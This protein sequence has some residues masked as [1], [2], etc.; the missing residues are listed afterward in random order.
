[1]SPGL[2][3]QG[4]QRAAFL[5][6][7][8][9]QAEQNLRSGKLDQAEN[10]CRA[11]L[12]EDS[13][14]LPALQMLGLALAQKKQFDAAEEIFQRFLAINPNSASVLSNLGN[15]RHLKGDETG[16]E[17]YYRKSIALQGANP[18]THF[19]L[20]LALKAQ[21]KLEDSLAAL[22]EA[23]KRKPDYVD[24]MVQSGVVLLAMKRPA[25]AIESLDR[26]LSLRADHFEAL[27]NKGLALVSLESY[28]EAK[29]CLARAAALNQN[30]H[31][32]FLALGKT[33]KLLQENELATSSLARAAALKPDD[34][35]T[36]VALAGV[37]LA[38]GW[39]MAA[40]DEA[41]KALALA[42]DSEEAL[43]M[44]GRV[45]AELNR[46]DES[47]ALQ[48]R[49]TEVAPESIRAQLVLGTAYLARGLTDEA[50]TVFE[51]ARQMEPSNARAFLNILRTDRIK[52]GDPRLAEM[53]AFLADEEKLAVGD[54][55]E[56][57]FAAGRIYDDLK[58]YDHAFSHFEK[59]NALQMRANPTQEKT[60]VAA[61]ERTIQTFTK[62]FIEKR[63][64]QG[65]SSR[66]PIFVL[67]M[68]RSG[69]TL[70]EQIISSHPDVVGAGEVLDF[71]IALKILANRRKFTAPVME[72]V[73]KLSPDDFR[74]I[75]DTYAQRL[76]QRAPGGAHVTDKLPGNYNRLGLIHLA[77]PHAR[78]IHCKRDPVDC[79]LSIYSNHFAEH[80][81]HA[82]DLAKLG[83]FYRRYH[84]LMEHWRNVLPEGTFLDVQYEDTVR[85]LETAA[86]RIIA[87]CGLEWDPRCLDF[88]K[89]QRQV[90]TLSITQVRQ[91]IYTSSVER[92]R[93]YEKHLTPL[94]EAL[95]DLAPGKQ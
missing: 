65:S 43:M 9:Q 93:N 17:S 68:P 79:C 12:Q 82:N 58:D 47:I 23:L 49:A 63:R 77:L 30:D 94:L 66:V 6:A 33:L 78:I 54:R 11:I 64:N 84:A 8:L 41:D 48:K 55:I 19:N 95:G 24:A 52:P 28:E 22:K 70:S 4:A 86:R 14:A 26:A 71:E 36:H 5:R 75:G 91:P 2:P 57:H 89:N 10:L 7:R 87:Y 15:L 81:E 31:R 25:E 51:K 21:G 37:F 50:R 44:K 74:E 67:G 85:D 83:R 72:L 32:V 80:L 20:A 90:V 60:Q 88:Q 42:P 13:S 59:A 56:L 62:S 45:L 61:F 16:A 73:D 53:E 92:W 39:T 46:L 34:A 18:Q 69:T 27:F 29:R 35:E 38:D 76:I 40:L 3:L 1:M